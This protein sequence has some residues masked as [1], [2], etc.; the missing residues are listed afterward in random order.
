M[1]N[2]DQWW[3]TTKY[4]HTA[5]WSSRQM[6]ITNPSPSTYLKKSVDFIF[7]NFRDNFI[8]SVTPGQSIKIQD[9]P[10]QSGMYGMYA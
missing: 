3:Y 1:I 2:E 7:S 6:L 10:G 4:R 5:V 8:F 9:C